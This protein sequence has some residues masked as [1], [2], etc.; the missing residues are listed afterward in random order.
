MSAINQQDVFE[1]DTMFINLET[2]SSRSSSNII[3]DLQGPMKSFTLTVGGYSNNTKFTQT[4]TVIWTLPYDTGC[5]H[6]IVIPNT[7]YSPKYNYRLLSP[8]NWAQEL[9]RKYIGK[10]TFKMDAHKTFVTW[11]DLDGQ[12][13]ETIKLDRTNIEI[14]RTLQNR[15]QYYTLKQHMQ[16]KGIINKLSDENYIHESYNWFSLKEVFHKNDK[17]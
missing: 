2:G 15:R 1:Q 7:L 13:Q 4:G 9:K 12:H 17:D 6:D 14:L 16:E 5:L 10:V 3:K 8:Q 11:V